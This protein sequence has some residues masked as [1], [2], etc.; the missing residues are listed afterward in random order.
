LLV[1]ENCLPVPAETVEAQ[2]K[3]VPVSNQV[4]VGNVL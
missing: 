2:L 3:V 4:L 1:I